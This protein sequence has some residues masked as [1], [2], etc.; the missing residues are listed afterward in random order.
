LLICWPCHVLRRR[1]IEAVLAGCAHALR[2]SPDAGRAGW[3]TD[4]HTGGGILAGWPLR[5]TATCSSAASLGCSAVDASPIAEPTA[6]VIAALA[7]RARRCH[8]S[9][10]SGRRPCLRDLHRRVG[11]CPRGRCRTV[12]GLTSIT[13]AVYVDC[14]AQE[15][16]HAWSTPSC[17]G[18][19]TYQS[20]TAL[21][22]AGQTTAACAHRYWRGVSCT[23]L[24]SAPW[25]ERRGP[26]PA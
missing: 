11:N 7:P 8:L 17:A 10:Q 3:Q 24:A 26:A 13:A 16:C 15:R 12:A 18:P 19:T 14:N 1:R 25:A 20:W 9:L 2:A 21:E 22:Q 23:L 4:S 5:S 6:Q